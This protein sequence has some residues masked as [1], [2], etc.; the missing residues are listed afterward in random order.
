MGYDLYGISPQENKE[1][2]KR[3]HEIMKEYGDGEG[4]LNWKE[5][6]PDEIKEEYWEIKDQYQKDNPGEYFR[7]NVWFWR[8]LWVFVC[9][10]CADILNEDDMMGGE[11]N[12][13]YEISEHK[14]E[15]I[16]R[17]LSALL[18]D[19]TV[20]EVDRISALDRAKAKAHND[21]IKE[22]QNEIRDKVHKEH[23]K[24]VAPANYPEPYYTE[25]HNLQKQ[26]Q[27]SAH[28]PFDKENIED[29]A[30]F[31]LESGGFEIC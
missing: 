5:N 17:R 15:L 28:Y 29:F 3:Y 14:A 25:W 16:G 23:G 20:D 30:K 9:N 4:F 24:D 18:A 6:V 26:E 27:W 21:E 31:C 10:N 1:F 12:S 13:G 7:N 2:P 22:Q 11:S 19:G 8:P